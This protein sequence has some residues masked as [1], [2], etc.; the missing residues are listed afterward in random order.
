M[1]FT[2]CSTACELWAILTPHRSSRGR[3][4]LAISK[5][6]HLQCFGDYGTFLCGMAL[7]DQPRSQAA[8]RG[9]F[10][11]HGYP[12]LWKRVSGGG[13]VAVE[14]SRFAPDGRGKT[15]RVTDSSASELSGWSLPSFIDVSQ[16]SSIVE[17]LKPPQHYPFLPGSYELGPVL[18]GVSMDMENRNVL[19]HTR[20]N[21][22]A[23]R[24]NEWFE[25]PPS[26]EFGLWEYSGRMFRR[27]GR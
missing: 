6:L 23:N 7:P 5:A 15:I 9:P 20:N 12:D 22:E 8:R 14:V 16:R 17:M 1:S 19:S 26:G 25:V 11:T 10:A 27:Y 3:I 4:S 2:P 21:P 24:H 18:Y 13:K